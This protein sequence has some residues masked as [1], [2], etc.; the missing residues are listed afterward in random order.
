VIA[1]APPEAGGPLD[2]AIARLD[3]YDW[4]IFTSV[5]GV[6]YFWA[7]LLEHPTQRSIAGPKNVSEKSG[8]AGFSPEGTYGLACPGSLERL[9]HLTFQTASQF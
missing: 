1:I 8:G 7:R 9:P 5:N 6:K 3:S 4:I 2:Q